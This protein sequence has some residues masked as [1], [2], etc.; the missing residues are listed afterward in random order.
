MAVFFHLSDKNTS[1]SFN[2][3]EGAIKEKIISALEYQY[4]AVDGKEQEH[5]VN[6]DIAA[7]L[8]RGDLQLG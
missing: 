7:R 4:D 3:S 8:K 5:S 1:P 6:L 2:M